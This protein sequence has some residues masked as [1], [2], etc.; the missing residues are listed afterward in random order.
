MTVTTPES[1]IAAGGAAAGSGPSPAIN[2][3]DV[4][5]TYRSGSETVTA[6]REVDLDI[7]A[8]EFF[9][10]LGPSGCGK[11][12]T[13]RMIA[14]FD[15]PTEGDVRLAGRS[16]LGVPANH[17]DVNMVFQSYALFPHMSVRDNVAFG[18]KRRKVPGAEITRRVGEMLE[19]VELGDRAKHKPAQLSGGQQQRVALARALVN[20][21]GALLLDEPLGALDLKL[22]QSMQHE[23]KRIQREVGITFV[24]VTH[25]QGEALT[26]SDR[27]AVMNNGIVEQLGTPAEVYEQP[28]SRFVA[29]FIGTSNLL[30]GTAA[31][32]GDGCS[33]VRLPDG[34]VVLACTPLRQGTAVDITV[35][36][37]KI[38]IT[39]A[40]PAPERSRVRGTV[41]DTVYLGSATH[42]TVTL[43]CGTDM[44]VFAQNASDAAELATPGTA[45]WLSW[46][47]RHS[48]VL[49]EHTPDEPTAPMTERD[50]HA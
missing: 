17:R 12:T 41:T 16:V 15:E 14:G 35:R 34:Q 22:R 42:Y 46:Q 40:E 21:P 18:L 10:L 31:A 36:P 1:R 6:V 38:A 26:M 50:D 23:L 4:S 44:V 48:F 20:R 5:K 19:L 43:P 8:G 7:D 2:L 27:I 24:Y 49:P 45:V 28:A 11:T 39:T 13:M 33:Q 25:D 3:V 9:S 30:S 47:P 37:E 32:T 29:G